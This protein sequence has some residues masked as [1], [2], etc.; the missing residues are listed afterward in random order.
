MAKRI[1]RKE[2]LKIKDW[3]KKRKATS[4]WLSADWKS[5]EPIDDLP[6]GKLVFFDFKYTSKK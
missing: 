3:L 5:I 1:T 4:L 2:V 6:K